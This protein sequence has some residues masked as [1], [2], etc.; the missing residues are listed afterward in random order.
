MKRQAVCWNKIERVA[1]EKYPACLKILLK[2]AGYDRLNSLCKIDASR[3][4]EIEAHLSK[5]REWVNE[6]KCCNSEYY[7]NLSTFQFLPGHKTSLL[8][9]PEKIQRMD[10]VKRADMVQEVQA[11]RY[12]TGF[13]KKL[14]S[15]NEV[16]ELLV[17]NMLNYTKKVNF[18]L[19]S[20]IISS[21]NVQDFQ[22]GKDTD[23]FEY[24][25]RFA[26]P[27]C[28]RVFPITFKNFWMTS[29]LTKHLKEHISYETDFEELNVIQESE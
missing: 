26:C 21:N 12:G 29:N 7:K 5:H 18:P 13:S 24:K 17:N 8:D 1:A 25:C 14:R 19:S 10:G 4:A 15:D 9:L 28:T 6:L 3:I 2:R 27:F 22:K 11:S 16:I 20:E 23:N